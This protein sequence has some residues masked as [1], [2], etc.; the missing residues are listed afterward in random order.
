MF[1]KRKTIPETIT[2]SGQQVPLVVRANARSKR[3]ILRWRGGAAKVVVT[4]PPRCSVATILEFIHNSA[5]WLEAQLAKTSS[6]TVYAD[7]MIL[8]LLGKNYTLQHRPSLRYRTWWTEDQL[9]LHAPVDQL[10]FYT[11]KALSQFVRPFLKERTHAYAQQLGKDVKRI[12]I[13]DTRSRW[14]SC[15]ASGGISYCWR[16]VFAPREVVDYVCAHEVAHMVE[17]NHGDAFWEIV[18]TFCPEYKEHQ[19]WLRTHGNA[20]LQY[21]GG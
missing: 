14:G 15:S 7:G 5:S 1:F 16:L 6:P 8:P 2:V 4:T 17:M 12:T 9:L 13:K 11:V 19:R 21:A 3:L 20:L 18:A 10:D